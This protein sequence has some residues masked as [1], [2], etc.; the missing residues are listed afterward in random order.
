MISK[1][2]LELVS[3][4]FQHHSVTEGTL[5]N[6]DYIWGIYTKFCEQYN[7]VPVPCTGELLV[8]YAVFLILQRGCSVP[9]IRNHLSVI[10]NYHKMHLDIDLPSPSQY[11]PLRAV[12]KVGAK[13]LGRPVKQKYPVTPNLLAVLTLTLPS[14]SPYRTAYNLFFFGLPRVG[15]ILPYSVDRFDK[16]KHLTWR[17]ITVSEEGVILR[18]KVTKTIQCFERDLRIPIAAS[19]ER[20]EFCVKNGLRR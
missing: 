8:K 1:R 2:A 9:T 13:Y 6:K 3:D 11:L 5:R 15:N 14:K 16:V 4:L 10:K 19:P 18:L 20:P 12:L 7:E 17:D